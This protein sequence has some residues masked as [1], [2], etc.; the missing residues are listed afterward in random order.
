MPLSASVQIDDWQL[1]P[2]AF[3]MSVVSQLTT[4]LLAY[5]FRLPP[6]FARILRAL[7]ALEGTA[8]GRDQQGTVLR[9]PP[10]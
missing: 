7:A 3:L 4:A 10:G 9:P 2:P 5:D 6:Y 8:T 1:L